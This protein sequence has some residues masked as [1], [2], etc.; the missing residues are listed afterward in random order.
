MADSQKYGRT[1]NLF[2]GTIE[3]GTITGQGTDSAASNRVRTAGYTALDAGTYT[4]SFSTTGTGVV[5]VFLYDSSNNFV[6]RIPTDWANQPY[7]FT[8]DNSYKIRFAIKHPE[9]TSIVP[10]DVT[11]IMLNTGSTA[12]PYQPYYGWLHN[13]RK[14]TTATEAVENPLYSDGTAITSY[15]ISGNTVQNGTGT[16][17]YPSKSVTVQSLENGTNYAKFNLADFPDVAVNDKVT[18]NVSGTNYS[19]TVKK[20]D[21]TYVYIENKEV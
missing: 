21:S 11:N 16:T 15:T 2:D 4:L 8:L 17:S 12:L 19:L 5:F 1:A 20:I 7:T 3:Q 18:I 14:L 6:G 10:S 9:E 13:L